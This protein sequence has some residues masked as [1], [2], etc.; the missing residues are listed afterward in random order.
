MIR[1]DFEKNQTYKII[2]V[3]LDHGSVRASAETFH[4]KEREHAILGGFAI[5]NA[6]FLLD[7]LHNFFATAEHARSGATELDEELADLFATDINK[8]KTKYTFC[9]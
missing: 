7:G 6:Q 9:T 2:I 4:L 8:T 1:D 3:D 5:L